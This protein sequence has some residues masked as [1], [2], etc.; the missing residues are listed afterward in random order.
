MNN[1]PKEKRV[2]AAQPCAAGKQPVGVLPLTSKKGFE[3]F[4]GFVT[5]REIK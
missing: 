2:A 4:A 1:K 3:S 5:K